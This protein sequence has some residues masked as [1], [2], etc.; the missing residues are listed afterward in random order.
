MLRFVG[1]LLVLLVSACSGDSG[2]S[3]PGKEQVKPKNIDFGPAPA[4]PYVQVV[5]E[6]RQVIAGESTTIAWR[7]E[8]ALSCLASGEW[9]GIQAESGQTQVTPTWSGI[10]QYALTCKTGLASPSEV[11]ASAAVTVVNPVQEA[12]P[13]E[14]APAADEFGQPTPAPVVQ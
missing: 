11:T 10:R 6:P 7:S 12:A 3:A 5:A 2:T 13:A 1:V 9:E 4:A 8:G 14:E